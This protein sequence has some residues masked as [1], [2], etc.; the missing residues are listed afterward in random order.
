MSRNVALWGARE[1]HAGRKFVTGV[2]A[3]VP[4]YIDADLDGN[5][6]WVADVYLGPLDSIGTGVVRNVPI[7]PIARNLI[8]DIRQPVVM[9]RKPEGRYT[10]IDRA[11][12]MPAGVSFGGEVPDGTYVETQHNF[13]ELGLRFIADIDWELEVL[14]ANP[15]E[16]LQADPE[17]PLQVVRGRNAFGRLVVGP[18][19]EVETPAEEAAQVPASEAVERR[20]VV[21]LE[22]LQATPDEP[23]QA[24]PDEVLQGVVRE[25][26]EVPI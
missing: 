2:T 8:T 13:A 9:E 11:K 23:L 1:L 25:V 6:E 26:V 4:A 24:S 17:Q 7:A 20:V 12:N 18:E 5:K 16:E 19:D 10:I 14:Q 22:P 15:G 21:R 3:S